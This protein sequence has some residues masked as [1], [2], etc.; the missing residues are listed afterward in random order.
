M[1]Y[2]K[3]KFML[4]FKTLILIFILGF[5]FLLWADDLPGLDPIQKDDRIMILAPHPDDEAIA[6]AGVI[7]QA[8]KAGAQVQVVYLTNG[9]HN[10]FAFIVYEKRIT[11]RQG[12][13]IHLGQVR[14][15]E[16]I[17]AMQLLGLNENNLIFLGYPD[18]G[19]FTI[20]SQCWRDAPP[21]RSMLTRISSVPY[22]NSLSP[23]APYKGESILK[24]IKKV[25]L[26]YKPTK[27]FVS[28]PADVNVDH[29][30]FYLFLEVALH[31]LEGRL[32]RPKIYP[33]LVHCV[34]W[35]M[36]RHYNPELGLEPPR[37]FL[38]SR[39]GW[40][41]LNLTPEE[42]DKKHKAIL[43]YR[44]QTNS[45][46]FY[47]LSF[48][49]RNEL[50]G[51]YPEI[52]LTSQPVR[53]KGLLQFFGSSPLFRVSQ[54]SVGSPEETKGQVSFA[55]EDGYLLVHIHKLKN[56]KSRFGIVL[57]VFGYSKNTPFA[58]MPKIRIIARDDKLKVFDGRK[59]IAPKNMIL[60]VNATS[61]ILRL[62]LEAL[63][64][65]DF[66]LTSLK[67]YG[68]SLPVDAI[69]FRKIKLNRR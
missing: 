22:K 16:A 63:G 11:L 64:K 4:K 14:R 3:I 35:P 1:L 49:R 17:K 44:S 53:Q 8:A 28:H 55:L 40:V 29:K 65:P 25:L 42:L 58:N 41:G 46:A 45:S 27:I 33:Y 48:A 47:L 67:A 7:Q 60:D 54:V 6:A 43:C 9:E 15:Q 19:T 13:F 12:E 66:I 61:L 50:F 23:G 32:A 62:P 30:A 36:P 38:D 69:G 10:Q 59:M 37:Q 20:F 56:L 21:A 68:G 39:I 2:A 52:E 34:N 18:F 24:D 31:D 51:D 57:Y 5:P 26:D